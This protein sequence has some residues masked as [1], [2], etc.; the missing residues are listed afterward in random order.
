MRVLRLFGSVALCASLLTAPCEARANLPPAQVSEWQRDLDYMV[1]SIETYHADAFHDIDRSVF[2]QRVAVLRTRMPQ[3]NRAQAIL[4]LAS[5]V[6]LVRDAHTG[7]GV[8]TS[9]PISFHS[10]PI[11][12]YQYVDGVFIQA[13][14]PQY[15]YLVGREVVGIGGVPVTTALERL[16]SVVMA[17]NEWTFRS[18]LQFQF[19]GEIFHALGLS[20]SDDTATIEVRGPT[21]TSTVMLKTIPHPFSIGYKPGPPEGSDWVDARG[22]VRVEF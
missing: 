10:F 2:E 21:G 20:Q 22:A 15:K 16:R 8:G 9:P 4:G 3:L 12:V 11:K 13:A 6:A 14:A 19:K 18:Q 5:I 1:K 17:T 7:F